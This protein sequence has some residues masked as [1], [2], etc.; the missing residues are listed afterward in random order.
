MCQPEV[1]TNLGG[2]KADAQTLIL[3]IISFLT[4]VNAIEP[5]T[6]TLLVSLALFDRM[7]GAQE[8]IAHQ[9]AL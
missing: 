5:S 2:C 7:N 8:V 6:S 9:R 3:P 1:L 4:G